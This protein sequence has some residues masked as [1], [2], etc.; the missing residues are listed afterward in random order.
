MSDR[1]RVYAA[2]LADVAGFRFD[3][4]VTRVFADMIQRSVPGYS[5]VIAMSGLLAQRFVQAESRVYDLGCSLGATSLAIAS[6]LSEQQHP[7]E[8]VAVD[9]S[10]P[11]LR[12]AELTLNALQGLP[13]FSFLLA[14]ICDVDIE[15]A[16]LVALNFTLQFVPKEQRLAL[17]TRCAQGMLPGGVLLL[18]EKIRFADAELN[19]LFSDLHHDFKRQHGYSDLEISQ[20][21]A[22]LENVLIPE[23]LAEHRERLL[24]AGFS[25]VELWFQCFNFASLVA[26]K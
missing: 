23:T 5:S 10:A 1:D 4:S 3:E 18:S 17:L 15:R 2:P 14:D 26:L 12:Q 19:Q 7:R 20:K 9:N 21:R 6:A 22:A 13:P 8:I 16:S 24:S 11:M 25:R